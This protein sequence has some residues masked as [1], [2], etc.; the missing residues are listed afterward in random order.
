[1]SEEDLE[2]VAAGGEAQRTAVLPVPFP[3]EPQ[4]PGA[5]TQRPAPRVLFVGAMNAEFNIDAACYFVE[6]IW[7]AVRRAAPEALCTIA[8][9]EPAARVRR[10]AEHPGVQVEGDPDLDGLLRTSRVAVS[11]AR[12]GTGIKVKVAQAMAAGLPVVGTPAGLSGFGQAGC[13]LR[14]SDPEAFAQQ[15]IQVLHDDDYQRKVGRDCHTCYRDHY[16]MQSVGPKVVALYEQMME[17]LERPAAA[18]SRAPSVIS[19][20]A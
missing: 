15:V 5:Q 2:D 19:R 7:P 8:G 18:R 20:G 10:L 4:D 9:R 13:L 14:A 16:W 11:P 17:E 3:F 1:M 6:R 12:I